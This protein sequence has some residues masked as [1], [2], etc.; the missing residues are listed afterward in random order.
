MYSLL[1]NVIVYNLLS[2]YIWALVFKTN[3][4]HNKYNHYKYSIIFIMNG[5][6]KNKGLGKN[7]G[8]CGMVY[9]YTVV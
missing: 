3:R 1:I 8:H 9:L 4:V 2:I 5:I 7:Y 6:T